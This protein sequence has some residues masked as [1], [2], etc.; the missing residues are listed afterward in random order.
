MDVTLAK[1]NKSTRE[2]LALIEQLREMG[3]PRPEEANM[4]LVVGVREDGS[5]VQLTDELPEGLDHV[6]VRVHHG[7]IVEIISPYTSLVLT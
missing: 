7:K 1:A 4:L 2:G 3:V 5:Q 6:F